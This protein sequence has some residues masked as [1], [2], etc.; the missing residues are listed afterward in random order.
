[1]AA[2]IYR[3]GF[4]GNAAAPTAGNDIGILLPSDDYEARDSTSKARSGFPK[5]VRSVEVSESLTGPIEP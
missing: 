4:S 1:L 2:G 5:L 3:Q